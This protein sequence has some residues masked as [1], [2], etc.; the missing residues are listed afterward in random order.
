MFQQQEE[1]VTEGR[2]GG[3]EGEGGG[4]GGAAS[5]FLTPNGTILLWMDLFRGRE[6]TKTTNLFGT[7]STT[8]VVEL[9]LQFRVALNK[10]IYDHRIS[11]IIF[12]FGALSL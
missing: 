8:R 1:D 4:G 2:E 7:S 5:N 6:G 3:G 12:L 11:I 9:F 10:R